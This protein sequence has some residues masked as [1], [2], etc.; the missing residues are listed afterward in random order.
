MKHPTRTCAA[1]AV[2]LLSLAACQEE[3]LTSEGTKGNVKI[4]ARMDGNIST[5]T[6]VGN[7]TEDHHP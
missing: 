3:M 5:R 1:A 6:C 4:L 7:T 2:C